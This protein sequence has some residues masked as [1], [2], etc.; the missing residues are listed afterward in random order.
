MFAI[1]IR[2]RRFYN[3]FTILLRTF[4]IVMWSWPSRVFFHIVHL[5]HKE[6]HKW[7]FVIILTT[8][9]IQWVIMPE[10]SKKINTILVLDANI[11]NIN[12]SCDSSH[13]QSQN[14][15]SFKETLHSYTFK[16]G[17]TKHY[18]YQR[19]WQIKE[20]K[21]HRSLLPGR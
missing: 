20:I 17:K 16:I 4:C 18:T 21:I 13:S 19:G 12:V 2:N 10:C 11:L 15:P 3:L 5:W 9:N 14:Y 1:R 8:F 6:S 7:Q